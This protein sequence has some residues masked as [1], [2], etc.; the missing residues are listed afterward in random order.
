MKVY[1][2]IPNSFVNGTNEENFGIYCN[3]FLGA[4]DIYYKLGYVS[5]ANKIGVANN[6]WTNDES[7]HG[8]Y[9]FLF[10]EDAIDEAI[11]FM[12]GQHELIGNV[13]NIVVYDIPLEMILDNIEGI[14]YYNLRIQSF[15]PI[16]YFGNPINPSE[17]TEEKKLTTSIEMFKETI[18]RESHRAYNYETIKPY[19][20]ILGMD[21]RE[22]EKYLLKL[23]D[24]QE[25]LKNMIIQSPLFKELNQNAVTLYTPDFDLQIMFPFNGYLKRKNKK[26]YV[27]NINNYLKDV[28]ITYEYDMEY[29]KETKKEIISLLKE[30]HWHQNEFE[31]NI[32]EETREKIRS[33]LL[34]IK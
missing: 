19:S 14:W 24:D 9:F 12:Q 5:F 32:R 6:Q 7:K 34:N 1:R 31:G 26:D 22:T 13:Y 25:Q 27:I 3:D 4:E 30:D 2:L 8:K 11:N 28:G 21:I 16:K 18:L 23:L 17:L 33:R 20:V 29:L 10:L 15:I